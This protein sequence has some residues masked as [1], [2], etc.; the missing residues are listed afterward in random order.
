MKKSRFTDS[1]QIMSILRKLIA[2]KGVPVPKLFRKHGMSA[3]SFYKWRSKYGVGL[4]LTM[5]R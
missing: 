2:D 3:A 5:K 4:A 1:S